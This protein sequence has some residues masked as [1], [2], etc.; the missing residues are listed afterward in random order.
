MRR[1]PLA[2]PPSPALRDEERSYKNGVRGPNDDDLSS[3]VEAGARWQTARE[4][5]FVV[6]KLASLDKEEFLMFIPPPSRTVV[7]HYKDNFS[8]FSLRKENIHF[9]TVKTTETYIV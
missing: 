8:T 6:N 7:F 5:R 9:F 3:F 4:H 1:L 2:P